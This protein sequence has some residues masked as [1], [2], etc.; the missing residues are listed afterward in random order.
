MNK[1]KT[2]LKKVFGRF[3]DIVTEYYPADDNGIFKG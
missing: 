3:G 1:L 2:V